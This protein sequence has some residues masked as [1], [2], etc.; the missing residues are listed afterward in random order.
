MKQNLQMT[1]RTVCDSDDFASLRTPE[2]TVRR[3]KSS[4]PPSVMMKSEK[5]RPASESYS[6]LQMSP[7]WKKPGSLMT[8]R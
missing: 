2:Q 6:G 3:R 7:S 8:I 4:L 5:P 1:K